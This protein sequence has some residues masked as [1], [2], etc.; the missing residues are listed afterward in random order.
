MPPF[1]QVVESEM[2]L[3]YAADE[4]E[5]RAAFVEHGLPA[6]GRVRKQPTRKASEFRYTFDGET[7]TAAAVGPIPS[8]FRDYEPTAVDLV[9]GDGLSPDDEP[10]A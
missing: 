9:I 6:D 5:A 4:A 2:F 8:E 1:V 10:D 7:L 3:T